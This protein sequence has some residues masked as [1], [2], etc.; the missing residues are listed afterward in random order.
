MTDILESE[1][2]LSCWL[3]ENFIELF[4]AIGFIWNGKLLACYIRYAKSL[5]AFVS[6]IRQSC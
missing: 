2:I 6:R 3:S 5:R 1:P 4:L